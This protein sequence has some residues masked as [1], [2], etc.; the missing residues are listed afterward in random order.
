MLLEGPAGEERLGL[1]RATSDVTDVIAPSGLRGESGSSCWA[2]CLS[3]WGAVAPTGE[4]RGLAKV[5]R[6]EELACHATE[7][8]ISANECTSWL[9]LVAPSTHTYLGNSCQGFRLRRHPRCYRD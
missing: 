7:S 6:R 4:L 2:L 8:S 5:E 9:K 3:C 1:E